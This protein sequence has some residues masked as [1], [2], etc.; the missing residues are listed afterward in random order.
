[1]GMVCMTCETSIADG[2]K[3]SLHYT[4][5]LA[6]RAARSKPA[7]TRHL[8]MKKYACSK[9]ARTT[10]FVRSKPART[11]HPIFRKSR[12]GAKQRA[13]QDWAPLPKLLLPVV[14]AH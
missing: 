8:T 2:T 6:R 9:P 12:T 14:P 3:H 10:K 5:P 1:M 11:R 4:T 13:G 7:R